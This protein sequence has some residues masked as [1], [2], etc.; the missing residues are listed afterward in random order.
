VTASS[1]SGGVVPILQTI[2][3]ELVFERGEASFE[4]AT[5][6]AELNGRKTVV[7]LDRR[8]AAELATSVAAI[9]GDD[10]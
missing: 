4:K 2:A 10:R 3:V 7:D 8:Q 6:T 9:I 5:V 1:G